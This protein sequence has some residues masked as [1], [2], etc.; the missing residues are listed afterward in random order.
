MGLDRLLTLAAYA[1][2]L[3]AIASPQQPE[4]IMRAG[5]ITATRDDWR[6]VM[7]DA[8]V[9]SVNVALFSDYL[10]IL[11][12]AKSEGRLEGIEE[13]PAPRRL[14]A[15]GMAVYDT[16]QSHTL[17]RAATD[18]V[19]R[20]K[21]FHTNK[22]LFEWQKPHFFGTIIV[23][24]SD[25]VAQAAA[26][27]LRQKIDLNWSAEE[28]LAESVRLFGKEVR[29]VSVAVAVGENPF[30]DYAVFGAHIPVPEGRWRTSA[31]VHGEVLTSV[32]TVKDCREA[33]TRAYSDSLH[34]WWLDSLR[35]AIS[36]EIAPGIVDK[37]ER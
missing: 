6:A 37:N 1:V 35:S 4:I 22:H 7:G 32:R 5:D 31:A 19:G 26:A 29:A 30:V 9:D 21:F 34:V 33:V 36:V 12:V 24:G 15:E 25:S 14:L 10:R 11:S 28:I 20:D 16:R 27:K 2:T 23:A 3:M 8:P 13:I 17:Q 18:S